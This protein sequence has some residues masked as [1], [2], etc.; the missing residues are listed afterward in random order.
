[1]ITIICGTN[2]KG[3]KTMKFAQHLFELAKNKGEENVK[4]LA[5]EDISADILHAE[6]YSE[7]GQVDSLRKIQDDYMIPANKYLFVIPEYNG[8]YPGILKLFLDA[9]SIRAYKETFNGKKAALV[10]VG[11]GRAG[12]LRGMDHLTGVLNHVGTLV[13]P[14][15]LPI[16]SLEACIDEDGNIK[17]DTSEAMEKQ[18]EALLAF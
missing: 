18:L 14:N 4:L 13:M 9:C 6:M 3:N 11:S 10:G 16:S 2:R 12:N 17:A 15:K 5:L 7:A 8:S 1:M